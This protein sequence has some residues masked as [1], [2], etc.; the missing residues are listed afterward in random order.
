MF[1]HFTRTLVPLNPFRII[2]TF[3]G[4]LKKFQD[5]VQG[6]IEYPEEAKEKGITGKVFVQFIVDEKGNITEVQIIRGIHPLLNNEALRVIKESPKW[7]P[8]KQN[9]KNVKVSYTIPITFDLKK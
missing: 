5:Y 9:G 7:T 3:G 2:N 1:L 6:K 8:G 4:D